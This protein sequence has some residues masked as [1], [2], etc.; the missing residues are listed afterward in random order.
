MCLHFSAEQSRLGPVEPRLRSFQFKSQS[1]HSATTINE[2]FLVSQKHTLVLAHLHTDTFLSWN[3][4]FVLSSRSGMMLCKPGRTDHIL[5]SIGTQCHIH[6]HAYSHADTQLKSLKKL[7]KSDFPAATLD[8]E[9]SLKRPR[10]CHL[11]QGPVLH[12][13]PIGMPHTNMALVF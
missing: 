5:C 9:I 8:W 10:A 3:V 11:R 7:L 1:L 2:P 4:I 12:S 13:C 6:W